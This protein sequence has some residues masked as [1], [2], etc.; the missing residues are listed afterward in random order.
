MRAEDFQ[1][2]VL[3][4]NYHFI[5][6]PRVSALFDNCTYSLLEI[7][8]SSIQMALLRHHQGKFIANRHINYLVA[9][10]KRELVGHIMEPFCHVSF[11][12]SE[13]LFAIAEEFTGFRQD[14]S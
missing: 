14:P 8:S 1:W 10:F 3:L 4:W 5:W 2:C 9:I 12:I 11:E 7:V 6:M 13:A